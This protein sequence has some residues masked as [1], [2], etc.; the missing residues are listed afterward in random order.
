MKT[1]ISIPDSIYKAAEKLTTHLG[2]TRSALYTE[3]I[4]KFLLEF[5]NDKITE[6]LDAVY[7]NEYSELDP[8]LEKLQLASIKEEDW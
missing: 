2:M 4:K 5:R 6:K 8:A 3:A 7:E 1:A